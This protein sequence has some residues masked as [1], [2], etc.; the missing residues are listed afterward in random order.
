ML[1][2]NN[3]SSRNLALENYKKD[4]EK[5][6]SLEDII[7]RDY[8]RNV[9][10][11]KYGELLGFR[12][13]EIETHLKI[14]KRASDLDIKDTYTLQEILSHYDPTANWIIPRILFS[15]GL[16]ILAGYAKAGKSLFCYE[17]I[18]ALVMSGDFLGIPARKG[19]VLYYQCEE[20]INTVQMR[21]FTRGFDDN[22]QLLKEALADN[23]L[24]IK[25]KLDLKTDLKEMELFIQEYKPQVVFIDSLRAVSATIDASENSP[26]IGK[27]LYPLQR[28][29]AMND[30]CGILVHHANKNQNAKGINRI[31]GNNAIAGANDGMIILDR[32]QAGTVS[33]LEVELAP[34]E[35]LTKVE[36]YPRNTAPFTFYSKRATGEGG[37]WRYEIVYE[38]GTNESIENAKQKILRY[39]VRICPKD[40]STEEICRETGL[41]YTDLATREA[42]AQLT[43]Y[44]L[45]E[46]KKNRETKKFSYGI[47]PS[48]PWMFRKDSFEEEEV[49]D[50]FYIPDTQIQAVS[51]LSHESKL[52]EKLMAC[53]THEEFEV[54]TQNLPVEVKAKVWDLL[55]PEEK[56]R[57]L[58]LIFPPK[59]VEGATIEYEN[60]VSAVVSLVRHQKDWYYK[61]ENGKKVSEQE[62]EDSD[63]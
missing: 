52:A 47:N 48:S 49:S 17:L 44:L 6:S 34:Q 28:V 45:I 18:N 37:R 14:Y 51:F 11:S 31:S 58:R 35:W 13:Q 50:P 39:L 5:L 19:R 20:P 22:E 55:S 30:V 32:V 16:Y 56:T 2:E 36:T 41:F 53:V 63:E 57:L 8:L 38:E 23:R 46:C 59:Y 40:S 12:P 15:T 27:Y 60:E 54:L 26:E 10:A 25:R 43:D 1:S 61:L 42:F 9:I 7:E 3:D 21:L 62:L 33:G 24:I 29:M 4:L